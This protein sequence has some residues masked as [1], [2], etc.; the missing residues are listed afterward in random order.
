MKV[1]EM[2]PVNLLNVWQQMSM[3]GG[4]DD[5]DPDKILMDACQKRLE[6]LRQENFIAFEDG[7]FEMWSYT[8]SETGK[9]VLC[10]QLPHDHLIALMEWAV[11]KS[12]LK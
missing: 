1:E 12:Q 9:I 3:F 4:Q 5:E 7:K 2:N 10:P 11:I 6:T 8:Q